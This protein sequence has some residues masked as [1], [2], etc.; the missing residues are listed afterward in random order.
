[1]KPIQL[2]FCAPVKTNT[3]KPVFDLSLLY[4][5]K[6]GLRRKS[7]CVHRILRLSNWNYGNLILKFSDLVIFPLYGYPYRIPNNKSSLIK[8]RVKL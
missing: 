7:K 6:N 3:Q 1:M 5:R 8:W 2:N 4:P